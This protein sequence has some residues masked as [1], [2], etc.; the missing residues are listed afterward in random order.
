MSR[1]LD[2]CLRVKAGSPDTKTPSDCGA[3]E[4]GGMVTWNVGGML[5]FLRLDAAAIYNTAQVTGNEAD[6]NTSN[7]LD[8]AELPSVQSIVEIPSLDHLGIALLA[9]GPVAAAL[10]RLRP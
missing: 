7:D 2:E 8:G 5:T 6:N 1:T 4:A 10:F 9:L 3:T